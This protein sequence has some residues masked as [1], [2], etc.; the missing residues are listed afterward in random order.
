MAWAGSTRSDAP[1]GS[2]LGSSG[3]MDVAIV[4]ALAQ[5][6]GRALSTREIA[7]LACRLEG[8][9]YK[10]FVDQK[11]RFESS[12]TTSQRTFPVRASS[13]SRCA[14]GVVR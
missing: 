6:A 7:D 4:A 9:L 8:E 2:G 13:A 14:S 11:P 1:H 5:A 12:I 3:A 10:P